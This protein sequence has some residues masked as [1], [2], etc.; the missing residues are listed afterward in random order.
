[1]SETVND[2]IKE[3]AQLKAC[4][5]S[6]LDNANNVLGLECKGLPEVGKKFVK[7]CNDL[8]IY[9]EQLPAALKNLQRL[10]NQ[11]YIN[12]AGIEGENTIRKLLYKLKVPRE[13][14]Y[15]VTLR[16]PNGM[17]TEIDAAII[18]P[19]HC[20]VLEVK[21]SKS[22]MII[23]E[24]GIYERL[25]GSGIKRDLRISMQNKVYMLRNLL[26]TKQNPSIILNNYI[27]VPVVVFVGAKGATIRNDSNLA[28][29]NE[30]ELI[31]YMTQYLY[32]NTCNGY[33]RNGFGLLFEGLR[34]VKSII[35]EANCQIEY[36]SDVDCEQ[37]CSSFNKIIANITENRN[38][39]MNHAKHYL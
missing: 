13:I 22:S 28:V 6:I 4:A 36:E 7:L 19:S 25:D 39:K 17:C 9:S 32:D 37:L 21:R 38:F 11:I 26:I 2:R 12:D 29:V 3:N 1:M 24:N 35:S 23:D 8:G 16:D 31:P 20:F 5:A 10:N 30:T 14:L 33:D 34:F 15:N 27:V 18:T